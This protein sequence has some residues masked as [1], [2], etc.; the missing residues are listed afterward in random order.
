MAEKHV[1]EMPK[2]PKQLY[3]FATPPPAATRMRHV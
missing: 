3:E 1:G 2:K